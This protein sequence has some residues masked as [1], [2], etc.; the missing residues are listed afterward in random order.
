MSKK[1]RS[2][3]RY[4]IS[5]FYCTECG[6][7]GINIVRKVGK[8]REPGHL[9]KIFCL[10]CNKE[11]NHAEVRPFGAYDYEDFEEEFRLGRFVDGNRVPDNELTLCTNIEC[12][13][14]KERKCWNCNGFYDCKYKVKE[15]K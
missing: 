5:D 13:Y 6:R 8:E 9:K 10:Y 14:N 1:G 12:K 7:R 4:T 2:N 11:T 3:C 15:E